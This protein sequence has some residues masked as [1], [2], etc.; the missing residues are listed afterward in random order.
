ML[1][2]VRLDDRSVGRFEVS[3]G[4]G[5]DR[6]TTH[7][8]ERLSQIVVGDVAVQ[9]DGGIVEQLDHAVNQAYTS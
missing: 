9:T 3:L 4:A 5:V 1:S 7:T 2:E 8:V 6:T